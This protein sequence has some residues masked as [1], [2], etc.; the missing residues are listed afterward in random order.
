MR[1]QLVGAVARK[2]S[3]RPSDEIEDAFHEAYTRGLMKCRWDRD[4]EVYGWL[5]RT[6]INWVIDRDR[7]ERLELV[8]DPTS[9]TFLEAA[10]ASQEPARISAAGRSA[11]RSVRCIARC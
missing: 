9:V 10:D 4:R 11:G 1:A 2:F 6:M 3:Q 5:R 8:A 7:R